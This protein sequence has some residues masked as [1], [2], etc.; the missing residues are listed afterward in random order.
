[1]ARRRI[2]R[3][4]EED[5]EEESKPAFEPSEFDET[6]FLQT[7]NRNAKMIYTSLGVAVLA[8][9]FSFIIMRGIHMIQP[10]G[11]LHFIIPVISPVIFVPLVLKLFVRFGIDY[12][13]MDWKKYAENGFMYFATWAAIWVLSMNP[14]LSDF[15]E[16]LIGEFVLAEVEEDGVTKFHRNETPDSVDPVGGLELFTVITD[17]YKIEERIFEI[18]LISDSDERLLL[19]TDGEDVLKS[20][21]EGYNISVRKVE[22]NL[23]FTLDREDSDLLMESNWYG[24]SFEEWNGSLWMIRIDNLSEF[25]SGEKLVFRIQVEDSAG[26]SREREAEIK[27]E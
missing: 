3:E 24:D 6:E 25:R 19:R 9:I 26:N 14:P 21:D 1:M 17:N 13:S 2:I 16:P 18:D 27:I 4:E 7:E 12:K 5:E 8:G 11:T 23:T 22:S 15:S 20:D 10:D